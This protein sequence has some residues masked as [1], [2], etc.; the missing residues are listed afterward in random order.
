[1]YG[2]APYTSNNCQS[3]ANARGTPQDRSFLLDSWRLQSCVRLFGG[4]RARRYVKPRHPRS[5]PSTTSIFHRRDL[6]MATRGQATSAGEGDRPSRVPSRCALLGDYR[7]SA[8]DMEDSSRQD[9]AAIAEELHQLFRCGLSEPNRR[10]LQSPW[11]RLRTLTQI[12]SYNS[13]RIS[14]MTA[15]TIC[16]ML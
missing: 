3:L 2:R 12:Q 8:M 15:H 1:V 4:R 5:P 7:T 6:V 13:I 10:R 9:Q 14:P 11:H 16:I